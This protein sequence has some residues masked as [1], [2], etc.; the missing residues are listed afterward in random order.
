LKRNWKRWKGEHKQ[1]RKTL[2][3]IKEKDKE[4]EVKEKRL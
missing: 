3:M 2:E 4:K 1:E